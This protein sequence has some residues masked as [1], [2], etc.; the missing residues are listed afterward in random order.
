MFW[1]GKIAVYYI[2]TQIPKRE[3]IAL[4][5]TLSLEEKICAQRF[6][7]IRDTNGYIVRHGTL[8]LLLSGYTGCQP[9]QAD[10]RASTHGKPYLVNQG[11]SKVYFSVS[12][13]E[14]FAVFAF[15]LMK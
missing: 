2:D 7:F 3:I 8:R 4:E 14:E 13:S 15:K 6:R 12:S 9:H 11:C 1:E 5:A 10:I